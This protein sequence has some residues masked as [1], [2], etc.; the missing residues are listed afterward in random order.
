MEKLFDPF[1]STKFTG[2]G[3]GLPVA[4]G[5]ARAHGG[6]IVVKSQPGQGT[7]MRAFLSMQPPPPL[8]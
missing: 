3:L 8:P 4:L 6:G 2:R 7:V 5:V 1:F